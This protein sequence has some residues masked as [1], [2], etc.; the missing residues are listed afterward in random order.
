[1]NDDEYI[2]MKKI[3]EMA[4]EYIGTHDVHGLRGDFDIDELV[5]AYPDIIMSYDINGADFTQ[6]LWRCKINYR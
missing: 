5:A 6:I 4:S 3:Y 2:I 1:M